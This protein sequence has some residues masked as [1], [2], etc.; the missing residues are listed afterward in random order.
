MSEVIFYAL[1]KTPI[2]KA[3]PKLLE[4]IIAAQN[5]V[6]IYTDTE[7]RADLYDTALWTYTTMGFLPHGTQKDPYPEEQP[8]LLSTSTNPLNNANIL[9]SLH[10]PF[11]EFQ[12]FHKVIYFFDGSNNLEVEMIRKEV[13]YCK[14]ENIKS[15]YWRELYT[16]GWEKGSENFLDL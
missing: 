10:R 8:I 12:N 6:L 14:N 1:N 9:L 4:K 7:E 13:E 16:G 15:T 11:R 2:G 5:R 3:V